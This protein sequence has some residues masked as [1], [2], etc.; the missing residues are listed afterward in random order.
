MDDDVERVVRQAAIV[1]S[2]ARTEPGVADQADAR[3]R[4]TAI[5]LTRCT[6][7]IVSSNNSDANCVGRGRTNRSS[8]VSSGLTA[9]CIRIR[10]A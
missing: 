10:I 6:S 7:V 2:I 8:C 4:Y 3:A 9:A 5:M 1:A